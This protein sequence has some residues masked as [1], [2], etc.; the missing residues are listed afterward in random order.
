MKRSFNLFAAMIFCGTLMAQGVDFQD[1][2]YDEVV[3]KAKKE[4]KFIFVDVYADWCKP[5]QRMDEEVF[6]D[7]TLGAFMNT[8]FVSY[9]ADGSM[10]IG[11]LLARKHGVD[12]Y[13]HYLFIDIRGNLIYKAKG[14]MSAE[15]LM[16]EAR[17]ASDPGLYN[18]Y[19]VLERK[20]NAG[21]RDEDLLAEFLELGYMKYKM[22]DPVLFDEY[23]KQLDLMDKQQE[24]VLQRV[25][26]YV[27]YADTRA[28]DLAKDYYLRIKEDTSKTATTDIREN[29]QKAVENAL[30]K[31]CE[32]RQAANLDD[33]LIKK[34]ELLFEIHP[35]D[36]LG[37]IKEVEKS[38][39]EFYLCARDSQSYRESTVNY[40]EAFLW[41]DE[42][43]HMDTTQEKSIQ[44][45]TVDIE[46]AATLSS[47]ADHYLEFFT[48]KDILFDAEEWVRQAI[49][50][51]DRIEY[52]AILARVVNAL[53]D[54][55]EAVGIAARALERA[56][57]EKSDYAEE[58][59]SILM[60]LV[61]VKSEG[62]LQPKE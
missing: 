28:Y 25:A 39:I 36:T 18:K 5:C 26:L 10:G 37:N 24:K 33:I 45:V 56:R 21:N 32:A 19:E 59:E 34:E 41:D 29:L 23:Y 44:Q 46:D 31:N 54:K 14:Y 43:F 8:N 61:S 1:L 15:Q 11:K 38:R 22:V 48:E 2:S 27:P 12:S 58:M 30:V 57:K 6:P 53:G 52:H 60:S 62:G 3:A 4:N 16:D 42:R 55:S 50:W 47:F 7:S 49:R 13:P 20:Y 17:L 40:V 35:T 9:K 51:D